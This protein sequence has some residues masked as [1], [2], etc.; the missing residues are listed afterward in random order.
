MSVSQINLGHQPPAQFLRELLVTSR[1]YERRDTTCHQVLLQEHQSPY[2]LFQ[3]AKCRLRGI[4]RSKFGQ[5]KP[6]AQTRSATDGAYT[7][8]AAPA[9]REGTFWHPHRGCRGRHFQARTRRQI[10]N[11]WHSTLPKTTPAR[12]TSKLY[13]LA[14]SLPQNSILTQYFFLP[15]SKPDDF[16][17]CLLREKKNR[18]HGQPFFFFPEAYLSFFEKERTMKKKI[19]ANTGTFCMIHSIKRSQARFYRACNVL[20]PSFSNPF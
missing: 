15:T 11:A 17:I 13:S 16:S 14:L 18:K 12:T 2:Q 9:G 7:V 5:G 1:V 8:A 19:K 6:Q 3:M 10:L 4:T 20:D